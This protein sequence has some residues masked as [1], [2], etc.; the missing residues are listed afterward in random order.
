MGKLDTFLVSL[1]L[2]FG[3]WLVCL[4]LKRKIYLTF[5]L[6]FT[7]VASSVVGGII[8]LCTIHDYPTYFVSFGLTRRFILF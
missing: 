8:K 3:I 2:A 6:F 7:Y 4:L 1:T 5:P